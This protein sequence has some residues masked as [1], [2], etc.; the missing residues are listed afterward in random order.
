MHQ[1]VKSEGSN[2][3]KS[4]RQ[5]VT[6]CRTAASNQPCGKLR[7]KLLLVNAVIFLTALFKLSFLV[8]FMLI[9]ILIECSFHS[10]CPCVHCFSH[11]YSVACF[12]SIV[13]VVPILDTRHWIQSCCLIPA[14]GRVETSVLAPPFPLIVRKGTE[15]GS[16]V[17]S[18]RNVR[19]LPIIEQV[20]LSGYC[21][22]EKTNKTGRM[23]RLFVSFKASDAHAVM[24][25]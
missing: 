10:C 15:R 24:V 9:S 2:G 18:V 4:C 23:R 3:M 21:R 14:I 20:T 7:T 22:C 19:A 1:S 6:P 12:A 13:V 17:P 16:S 5:C 11:R 25:I 8:A